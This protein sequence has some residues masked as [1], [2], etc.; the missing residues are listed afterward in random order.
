[1]TNRL[2]VSIMI[3]KIPTAEHFV[4]IEIE[5]EILFKTLYAN[6]LCFHRRC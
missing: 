2:Q 3:E 6:L 5:I 4:K 1:M